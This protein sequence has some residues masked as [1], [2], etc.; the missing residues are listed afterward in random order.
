MNQG[1]STFLTVM[2]YI[3]LTF[4]YVPMILLVIYSFNYSK[5]VPVWGGWSTRW[6]KVLFDSPEVWEAV[7]LSLQIALVN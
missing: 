5:L 1:R 6:Y 4:L 7:R 2:L 3:G